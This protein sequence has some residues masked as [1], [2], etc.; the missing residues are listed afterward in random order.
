MLLGLFLRRAHTCGCVVVEGGSQCEKCT[1]KTVNC[2]VP[3]LSAST[4]DQVQKKGRPLQCQSHHLPRQMLRLFWNC[5]VGL[6]ICAWLAFK[7]MQ[8]VPWSIQNS[9]RYVS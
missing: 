2:W 7:I 5:C 9:P 1:F 8:H 4:R 3:S 6:A